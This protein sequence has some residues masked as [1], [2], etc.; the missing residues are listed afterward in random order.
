MQTPYVCQEVPDIWVS[1]D[2]KNKNYIRMKR[3]FVF[4]GL[5]C[6]TFLPALSQQDQQGAQLKREITLYNPYK[7]SLQ[8]VEK[9]SFLPLIDDTV[10]FTPDFTYEINTTAFSPDYS[11]TPLKAATLHPDPLTKLYKSYINAGFGSYV[12]PL[13]EISISNERSKKGAIGFYG[14]HYSS[15]GKLV[16]ENLEK[17]YAGYMDNDASLYGKKFFRKNY[18][19][20]SLDLIQKTRYA[21]GYDPAISD[22]MADKDSVRLGLLDFGGELSFASLNLDS[23]EFSYDFSAGYDH[24]INT[25]PGDDRFS[26]GHLALGGSMARLFEGFYAGAEVSFDNYSFTDTVKQKSRY[27]F[28]ASPFIK[29][30]TDQWN[31]NLGATIALERDLV[32]SAKL[33]LYPDVSFGF[34]IVPE[35]LRFFT[36]LNGKLEVNDPLTVAAMNPFVVPDGS[37]FKMPNTSHSLV[38]SAGL[39]GNSGIG[40]TWLISGSYS[41]INNMLFFE[42]VV[43]PDTA[44]VIQRGNFFMPAPDDVDLL[45][46]HAEMGGEITERLSFNTSAGYYKYTMTGN[47]F[48]WNKPS[49]D[50]KLELRYNLRD[51][52]IAGAG[53]TLLGKRK[54]GVMESPTGWETLT[55]VTIEAPV[56]GNLNLGAEYRYTKI[57]SFW[58]KINNISLRRYNEWA[59]YPSQRFL[60]M[61]GFTYSL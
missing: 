37:L 32:S 55:P 46:L 51:K 24:L 40:G 45:T 5:A 56:H 50:G 21:Y 38:V 54:F 43:H 20:G 58:A 39:K 60:V 19:A 27:V 10:T 59:F 7:P 31:F 34:S 36:A 23:A 3:Y 1:S 16:L 57:L 53:L 2:H 42:N 12:T 17:V 48:P 11:I 52:I 35:Y 25:V 41:I 44:S 4:L 18:L 6:L 30:S 26:Q 22:Y 49:W 9:K 33:H 29:K 47:L 15:G 14:R 61:A 28:S 13:A 8:E